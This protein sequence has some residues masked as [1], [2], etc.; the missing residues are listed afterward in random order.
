MQNRRLLRN[1]SLKE[2]LRFAAFK[3]SFLC[4]FRVWKIATAYIILY[5]YS[6]WPLW[7]FEWKCLIQHLYRCLLGNI[8]GSLKESDA[9]PLLIDAIC[10]NG[11]S[12]SERKSV[13]LLI[14]TCDEILMEVLLKVNLKH[15]CCNAT[16]YRAN[17]SLRVTYTIQYSQ[18]YSL[19]SVPAVNLQIQTSMKLTAI[20]SIYTLVYTDC[21][22]F[23]AGFNET[24]S[25]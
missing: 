20:A 11:E 23:H 12:L 2:R 18:G 16:V 15:I 25:K 5:W 19:F 14:G 24:G 17:C 3:G 8:G 10:E 13:T 4:L 1:V 7:K 21:E 22:T 9:Y 6:L